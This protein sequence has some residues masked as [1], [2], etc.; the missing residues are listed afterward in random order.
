MT[1]AEQRIDVACVK[2]GGALKGGKRPLKVAKPKQRHASTT[3]G[4]GA[5]RQEPHGQVKAL[6]GR[7]VPLQVVERAPPTK[8]RMRVACVK[9]GGARIG[10]KR[11]TMPVQPKQHAS[12]VKMDRRGR[13][14]QGG[15]SV[16][17]DDGLARAPQLCQD[18]SGVDVWRGLA[19]R[20]PCGHAKLPKG[21][22]GTIQ[23][24]ER[25]AAVEARAIVA[26]ARGNDAV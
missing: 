21:F 1:P 2:R 5:A 17:A 12:P 10:L 18:R 26:R 15:G 4:A 22:E 24:A 20:Q 11:I 6:E 3:V 7:I 16:K 9:R 8:V 25:T 19:R 14:I 13:R 23:A